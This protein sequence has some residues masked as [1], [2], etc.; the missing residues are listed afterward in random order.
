[1]TEKTM[2]YDQMI[3][4]QRR[5]TAAVAMIA[6][7]TDDTNTILTIMKRENRAELHPVE[8]KVM[9]PTIELAREMVGKA[10]AKK[11]LEERVEKERQLEL[12]AAPQYQ[13]EE[14]K[15]KAENIGYYAGRP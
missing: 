4:L 7:A 5:L 12:D 3:E 10:A 2:T 6:K 15:E 14:D 9:L 8:W 11:A 1:M 13:T